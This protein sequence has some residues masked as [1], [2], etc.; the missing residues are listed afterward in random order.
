MKR[1]VTAIKNVFIGLDTKFETACLNLER[2]VCGGNTVDE[3][4]DKLDTKV[5]EVSVSA[6][7]HTKAAVASIPSPFT[8]CTD[9]F[10]RK[11]VAPKPQP[12]VVQAIPTTQSCKHCEET[13]P[14]DAGFC[15]MCEEQLIVPV[16]KCGPAPATACKVSGWAPGIQVEAPVKR[17]LGNRIKETLTTPMSLLAKPFAKVRV[18]V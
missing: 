11:P 13:I 18:N 2:K 10:S 3:Q 14:V 17:S 15:P 1:S 6:A 9:T 8:L 12:V 5:V 4:L 7:K 16:A